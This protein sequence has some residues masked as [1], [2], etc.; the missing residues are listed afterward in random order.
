MGNH[1][2]QQAVT[3]FRNCPK[4]HRLWRLKMLLESTLHRRIR[5]TRIYPLS[6]SSFMHV[7][8]KLQR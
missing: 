6:T 4:H 8:F 5:P 2:S 3:I 1:L 7:H